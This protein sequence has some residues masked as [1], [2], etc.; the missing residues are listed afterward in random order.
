MCSRHI[1]YIIL[2][3][4]ASRSILKKSGKNR[5]MIKIRWLSKMKI[6][7]ILAITILCILLYSNIKVEL[8]YKRS[9]GND[10]FTITII[11]FY[12]I[13]RSKKQVPFIDLVKGSDNLDELEI[14]SETQYNF[15]EKSTDKSTTNINEFEEILK[16]YKKLY[17]KF[18]KYMNPFMRYIKRKIN[19]NNISWDTEIGVGDA[20]QTAVI[21]GIIWSVKSYVIS[22]IYNN[23]NLYE[24]FINV[25]PNYNIKTLKTSIDCIFTIKLGDIINAG[26]KILMLQVKDGE[27]N[28]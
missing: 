12:G 24:V 15:K 27:K 9:D 8:N 11:A 16:K 23:Y 18:G 17:I 25:D 19:L 4:L 13:F 6:L 10:I 28:E 3:F 2:D 22:F 1:T 20:A 14:K 7:I 5:S 21:T 26:I